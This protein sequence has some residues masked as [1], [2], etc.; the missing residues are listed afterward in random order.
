MPVH[1]HE[2][3]GLPDG[4]PK[5]NEDIFCDKCNGMV[6]AFNNELMMPW[7]EYDDGRNVCVDCLPNRFP[8]GWEAP[9]TI[10][11]LADES[12]AWFLKG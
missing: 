11:T 10:K 4:H 3:D 12:T 9:I 6:H 2:E 7:V 8:E 5:A 1:D